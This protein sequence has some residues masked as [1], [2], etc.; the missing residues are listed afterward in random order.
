MDGVDLTT[1]MLK[2]YKESWID[3]PRYKNVKLQR[4]IERG[5]G[6]MYNANFE[7]Y[8]K[9][10]FKKVEGGTKHAA[11][12]RKWRNLLKLRNLLGRHMGKR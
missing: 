9:N 10:F 3:K 8:Q 2:K 4:F 6:M 7:R 1:R 11:K 12:Y 5:R